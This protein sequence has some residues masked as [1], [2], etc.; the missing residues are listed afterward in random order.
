MAVIIEDNEWHDLEWG[1]V[2]IFF[3]LASG[4]VVDVRLD[5]YPR[6]VEYIGPDGHLHVA[7][8]NGKWELI[9]NGRS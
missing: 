5:T 2:V 7:I 3:P 9:P 4:V 6:R 1:D 8:W